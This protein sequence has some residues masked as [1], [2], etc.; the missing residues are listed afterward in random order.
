MEMVF[1]QMGQKVKKE[2]KKCTKVYISTY[3]S[4][5]QTAHLKLRIK[6]IKKSN[7]TK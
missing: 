7:L 1:M 3:L 4:I 5:D 2:K 6:I